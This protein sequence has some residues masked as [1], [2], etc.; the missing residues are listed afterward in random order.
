ME[1]YEN[2][3]NDAKYLLSNMY[4]LYLERVNNGSTKKAANNF[5]NSYTI[6]EDVLSGENINDVDIYAKELSTK[7]FLITSTASDIVWTSSLSSDALAFMEHKFG[8]NVKAVAKGIFEL[9]KLI[10]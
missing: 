4:K 5:G 2:L 6:K 1:K 9:A 7:G 8:N 3:T 10:L